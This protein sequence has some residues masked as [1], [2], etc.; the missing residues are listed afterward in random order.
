MPFCPAHRESLHKR[1]CA[2]IQTSTTVKYLRLL[3]GWA[4]TRLDMSVQ[5]VGRSVII[6][7]GC[8]VMGFGS[9]WGS[10]QCQDIDGRDPL[11]PSLLNC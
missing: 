5:S 10:H 6:D 8:D 4:G 1:S 2:D 3:L 11:F 7:H 9:S